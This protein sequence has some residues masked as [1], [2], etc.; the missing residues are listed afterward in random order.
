MT[1]SSLWNDNTELLAAITDGKFVVWYYP[2]VVFI[3]DDLIPLTKFEKDGRYRLSLI[4][5]YWEK[6]PR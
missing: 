3:D 1:E 5:V 4:I 6:M 2:N